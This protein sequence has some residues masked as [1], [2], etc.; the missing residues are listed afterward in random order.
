MI[1]D[2]QDLLKLL[3]DAIRQIF[4]PALTGRASPGDLERELLSLPAR[5]GGP[6]LVNLVTTA[7]NEHLAS[8]HLT[9]TL[10]CLL[11]QQG[12]ATTTIWLPR[13]LTKNDLKCM[14]RQR[15]KQHVAD[16]WERLPTPVQ[17]ATDVASEKGASA[18]LMALPLADHAFDLQKGSFR[19]AMCLHYGWQ[20]HHLPSQ[21]VCG[22]EFD[23]EHAFSC[24][25]GGLPTLRHNEIRDILASTLSEVCVGVVREPTLQPLSGETFQR[26]TTSCDPDARLDIRARGFWGS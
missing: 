23:Q 2:I 14:K 25:T 20:L 10:V 16:L 7:D 6:G 24:P 12:T 19:D 4:I 1:P 22:K 15:E 26:R 11:A 13:Q 18:W 8:L 9:S 3:K 17:R 21:C 5:L